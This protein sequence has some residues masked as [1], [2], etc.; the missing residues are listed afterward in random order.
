MF[1]FDEVIIFWINCSSNQRRYN[2][3]ENLLK[4]YFPMNER[5]HVE[6]VMYKPK[7]QGVTMAHT[8]ALM[9]GL[10]SKKPFIVLEDDVDIEEGNF[11][12]KL[13]EKNVNDIDGD[14]DAIY[15]G[16]SSWAKPKN[17]GIISSLLIKG[18]KV[19]RIKDKIFFYKGAK[20]EY[21]DDYFFKI[22]EMY[23][24]HAILYLKEEYVVKTLKY[25]I[26]AVGQNKPHDIY[27]PK[28]LRKSCIYGLCDSFFYQL[29]KIGGQESATKIYL[30]GV[31]KI[32]YKEDYE[33]IV[34]QGAT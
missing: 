24:A 11:D 28:L 30:R 23:G 16:I 27:L 17:R 20:G 1:K 12:I 6:A 31:R 10:A 34:E 21:V 2:H 7:Y 32:N 25:C 3:M 15:L 18:E 33:D 14:V 22:R 5:H 26:F 29:A 8:V 13:L 4:I 19:V 9:K